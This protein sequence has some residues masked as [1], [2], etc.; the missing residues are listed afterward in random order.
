MCAGRNFF[1]LAGLL[2]KICHGEVDTPM[3][4]SD[5]KDQSPSSSFQ[6]FLSLLRAVFEQHLGQFHFAFSAT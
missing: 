2:W 6:P 5:G 1:I 4:G 3:P